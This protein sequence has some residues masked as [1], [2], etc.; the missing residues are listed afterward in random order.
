ML[1]LSILLSLNIRK[2]T[3]LILKSEYE[4][5][6]VQKYNLSISSRNRKFICEKCKKSFVMQIHLN[7]HS[8]SC[9]MKYLCDLRSE[10]FLNEH[11]LIQHLCDGHGQEKV[12]SVINT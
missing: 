12:I 10:Y 2:I 8:K 1:I 5:E 7:S 11:D 3:Y 9:K 6:F 4:T